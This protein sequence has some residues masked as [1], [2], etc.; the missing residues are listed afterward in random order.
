MKFT[1]EYPS[2]M[3]D[4]VPGFLMPEMI[5]SLAQQA[6]ECGFD[7]VAF[8]EH[9]AP[10]IKWRHGGGH[11]TLDPAVALTYVAAVTTRIRLMTN[12][13]VLP[14][15]NPYLAA[16]TLT[17][18]DLVSGGRLI[19]GVGAGYL[20]SEFSALG[21]DFDQRAGLLDQHLDAL[22]RI[23]THPEEPVASDDFA[24]TSPMWL[25]RPV[26]TPHPPLWIGGNSK[27]ALRR[28]VR[29]GQ[30]WSPVI[31]PPAVASSIRTDAI[32]S[33]MKFGQVVTQ[34]HA[35][36]SDSHRDPAAVDIQIDVPTIDFDTPGAAA[37][38]MD[39][40]NDLADRGATW[41]IVHVDASSLEAAADYVT[42]F[43]DAVIQPLRPPKPTEVS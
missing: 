2:E 25:C 40:L 22:I 28:V 33:P 7:A 26:Q 38:T 31:A 27:A 41:A 39:H 37:E 8:S 29:Y 32:D 6:E 15:R 18:L 19:A 21:V 4:A 3:P 12:L 11:D 36:L 5:G 43:S 23:W 35:A 17:S 34:L 10:S 24:A 20:R 16:K 1:L 9:P 30:G 42:A 13:Y 14:F